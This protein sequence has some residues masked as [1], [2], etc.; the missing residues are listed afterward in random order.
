MS[1]QEKVDN[2][3]SAGAIPSSELQLYNWWSEGTHGVASGGSVA[4]SQFAMPITT[5][6]SFNRSLW[7]ATGA[8]VGRESMALNNKQQG[9]STYWAPVVNLARSPKWGRNLETPGEDSYLSGEYAAH[10]VDGMQNSASDPSHWQ[11]GATCKHFVAN[12]ME[13]TT[14]VGV[15]HDRAEFDANVSMQDLVSDYLVPF[16]SCIENVQGSGLMCSYNAVNGVPSCANKWLMNDIAR[17]EWG[18]MHSPI[19]ITSDCTADLDVYQQH[20]YTKTPEEA[21][22]AILKAGQDINCGGYMA[23]HI[24]SAIQQGLASVGDLDTALRH[25]LGVRFRLGHFD[26]PGPLQSIQESVIC[27]PAAIELARDGAAQGMVLLKNTPG[28]AMLPLNAT[29]V[30]NVAVI[31]PHGRDWYG[32]AMGYYYFGAHGCMPVCGTNATNQGPYYTVADAFK[33]YT[34]NVMKVGGVLNCSTTDESGIP[35]AVAAAAIAD[36]V[37][38]AVGTDLTIAAEGT[39]ATNLTL[40]RAQQTLISKVVRAAKGKVL[41]LLTTAVPL[42]ISDL[43][44]NDKVGAIVHLGVPGTQAIGVGDVLFGKK[45][46]AGRL[47]QTWYPKDF[48][49]SLS[50]FDMNLRPGPSEYPRP[51]C[52]QRP[53]SACPRAVNPGVTHRYYT[54]EAVLPFGYGLSY[55]TF[56]YAIASA[57]VGPISLDPLR[58]MLRLTQLANRTFVAR[59]L[60]GTAARLQYQVNVTNVGLVDSDDVVLG[61]MKPPGAGVGGVPLQQLFAFERVHVKA[62]ESVLVTIY[63]EMHDF[64]QVGKHGQRRELTGEYNFMFG[65]K[66]TFSS[67]GGYVEHSFTTI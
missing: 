29:T 27:D 61:F 35:A 25:T 36:T 67:G 42:D 50:I 13:H 30:G 38:L 15:T 49:H 44:S 16:Q 58:E 34:K 8:Q 19:Y 17:V 9:F 20:N 14:E 6:Q 43:L 3:G 11:A 2:M 54:G 65:V 63:P 39:D 41:V 57:P 56:S 66:E 59:D 51:D 40:S 31:G 10:F 60:R 28:Q 4:R 53:A 22:A 33:A 21:V 1:L 52:P 37:V 26:P 46:I 48:G 23:A 62:G 18:G 32:R 12:S 47:D 45:Q 7:R 24:Q 55:T 64:S 5:A